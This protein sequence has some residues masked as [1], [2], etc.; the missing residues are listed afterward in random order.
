MGMASGKFTPSDDYAKIQAD[1]YLISKLHMNRRVKEILKEQFVHRLTALAPD[2]ALVR[3]GQKKDGKDDCLLEWR[4]DA[5]HKVWISF[6]GE[7]DRGMLVSIEA[8]WATE[9]G[10]FSSLPLVWLDN[11]PWPEV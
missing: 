1:S 9:G 5:K 6:D 4:I 7:K 8:G 2:I 11:R 3:M 10:S